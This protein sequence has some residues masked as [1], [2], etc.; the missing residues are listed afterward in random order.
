MNERLVLVGREVKILLMAQKRHN[1]SFV[2]VDFLR[3]T[4]D[5]DQVAPPVDFLFPSTGSTDPLSVFFHP[6]YEK[7]AWEYYKARF[8]FL[9]GLPDSEGLVSL[10]AWAV[11]EEVAAIL[12][13]NVEVS[14]VLQAGRDFYKYRFSLCREGQACGWV[15]FLS[16]SNGA[17]SRRQN[18][19][20]HVCLEGLACTFA[21]TAWKEEMAQYLEKHKAVITRVDLALDLFDGIEGGIERL[22]SQY[23]AG[24]MDVNGQRPCHGVAGTWHAEEE[25]DNKGR[26]FYFG[27]RQAGK[28]TNVY[29][30]GL[31]LF[32]PEDGDKWVRVELRYGNQ[33]RVLPLDILRRA[34]DFFAG[35]SKW[36]QHIL[37]AATKKKEVGISV[38][39]EPRL[40]IQSI[41]AELT[42]NIRWFLRTAGASAALGLFSA[43]LDD[44]VDYFS[45][46]S[47]NLPNRLR[48]FSISEVRDHFEEVFFK[49]VGTGQP[50]G[51]T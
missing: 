9:D 14:P 12:Q 44:F 43:P 48:K 34:A 16:S 24:E 47:G 26:S 41:K 21:K 29:E 18:E 1:K 3:F 6:N 49:V 13:G 5:V 42:R 39:T 2:H 33:K 51:S 22:P 11:A 27:S 23:K 45:R 25:K 30:K 36:H 38:K 28:L 15:G 32:G 20:I 10:R 31:Q 37:E 17:F 46:I 50:V 7:G 40:P 35:A 4:V 8:P 19:T